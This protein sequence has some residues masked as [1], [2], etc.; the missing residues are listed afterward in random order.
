M[1]SLLPMTK[2]LPAIVV[3]SLSVA[4]AA[5]ATEQAQQRQQARD[6]RQDTRSQSRDTKQDCRAADD[7]SNHECRQ[8]KHRT[9]Q[10]GRQ[11]ARDIKY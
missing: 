2:K 7:K 3:I 10:D 4:F 6:V 11:Q 5:H 9:K 1:R 8:D